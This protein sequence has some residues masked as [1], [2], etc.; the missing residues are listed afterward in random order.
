MRVLTR[1]RQS[2]KRQMYAVYV[3]DLAEPFDRYVRGTAA[4]EIGRRLVREMNAAELARWPDGRHG[5]PIPLYYLV[6]TC[7]E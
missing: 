5:F 7:D 1:Q 6:R 4:K 2:T 3:C